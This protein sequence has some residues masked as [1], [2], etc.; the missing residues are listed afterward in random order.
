MG[1]DRVGDDVRESNPHAL[2]LRPEA[3]LFTP[4]RGVPED[5]VAGAP[6][7]DE[8]PDEV[9]KSEG[10]R[11]A[12]RAA[13]GKEPLRGEMGVCKYDAADESMLRLDESMDGR[14]SIEGRPQP[15]KNLRSNS[16]F[17]CV[18]VLLRER[19]FLN[20]SAKTLR[21][22][23]G[24]SESDTASSSA[25]PSSH[26]ALEIIR[27][28]GPISHWCSSKRAEQVNHWGIKDKINTNL[29][30]ITWDQELHRLKLQSKSRYR[31]R[32]GEA[33]WRLT[34]SRR[35]ASPGHRSVPP[36]ARPRSSP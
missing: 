34:V 4:V 13:S 32:P 24:A 33:Y 30:M 3:F 8:V 6:E 25:A 14:V 19:P 5:E 10:V 9:L 23:L 20:F 16:A 1:E 27:V 7:P 17:A 12:R 26:G 15:P 18:K 2:M 28:L 11:A 35:S 21:V 29:K 31:S 22:S 36:Y